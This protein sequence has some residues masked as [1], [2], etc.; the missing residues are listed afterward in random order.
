LHR[1]CKCAQGVGVVLGCAA[2]VILQHSRKN[3][4]RLGLN[5][6]S[7]LAELRREVKLLR[8]KLGAKQADKEGASG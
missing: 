5:S 1:P 7:K 8:R 2:A 3:R 6:Y 4:R